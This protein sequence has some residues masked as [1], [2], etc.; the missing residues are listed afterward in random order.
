MTCTSVHASGWELMWVTRILLINVYFDKHYR[1]SSLNYIFCMRGFLFCCFPW[2]KVKVVILKAVFGNSPVQKKCW[3]IPCGCCWNLLE[4]KFL[5]SITFFHSLLQW[6]Q[7]S[8][9]LFCHYQYHGG[10]AQKNKKQSPIKLL[11]H[12]WEEC[13]LPVVQPSLMALGKNDDSWWR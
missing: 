6:P 8:C 13:M 4:P 10:L 3:I 9:W 7:S 5:N 11:T 1:N 12:R 2:V